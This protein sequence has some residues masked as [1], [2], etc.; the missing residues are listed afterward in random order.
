MGI[1]RPRGAICQGVCPPLLMVPMRSAALQT[2]AGASR[3]LAGRIRLRCLCE[4]AQPAIYFSTGIPMDQGE[5]HLSDAQ[6]HETHSP[7]KRVPFARFD[8]SAST[9]CDLLPAHRTKPLSSPHSRAHVR[10]PRPPC[11]PPAIGIYAVVSYAVP[12]DEGWR[13]ANV[14]ATTAGRPTIIARTWGVTGARRSDGFCPRDFPYAFPDGPLS[15]LRFVVTRA[16]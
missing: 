1:G 16:S 9:T 7:P 13:A 4:P 8:P 11:R 3:S 6:R 5:I 2:R 15:L 14:R 12:G 10:R